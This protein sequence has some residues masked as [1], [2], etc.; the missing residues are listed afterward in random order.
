[1]HPA[2]SV[3]G[4]YI[5]HPEAAYFDVGKIG[6]DQIEDY[7][8]R[9]GVAESEMETWLGWRLSYEPNRSETVA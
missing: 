2:A 9:K 8:A 1:M 4:L 7:A 5:A 6:R 3:C